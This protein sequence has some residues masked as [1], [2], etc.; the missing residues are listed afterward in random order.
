MSPM[1]RSHPFTS[2]SPSARQMRPMYVTGPTQLARC[3]GMMTQFE[4]AEF[5]PLVVS[6]LVQVSSIAPAMA[7]ATK[8]NTSVPPRT[9]ASFDV[10]PKANT[11]AA[12]MNA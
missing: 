9:I 6:P 1:M 11:S 7:W 5:R 3:S 8:P 12:T 10:R 4:S 2:V